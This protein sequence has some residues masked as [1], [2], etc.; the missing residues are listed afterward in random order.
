MT[1]FNFLILYLFPP[2]IILLGFFGNTMGLI[3][4]SR[5]KMK[6]LGPILV[7]KCLFISDTIYLG[8]YN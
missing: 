5:K 6:Q 7:F 1:I 8:K 3:V 4:V 2:T